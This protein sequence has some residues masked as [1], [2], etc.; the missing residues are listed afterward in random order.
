M[1]IEFL[2]VHWHLLFDPLQNSIKKSEKVQGC[3]KCFYAKL[4]DNLA[5]MIL[6]QVLN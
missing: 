5:Q 6:F 2:G 1:S 4:N 3:T